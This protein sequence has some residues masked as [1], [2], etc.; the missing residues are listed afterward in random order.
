MQKVEK[1]WSRV[2][3]LLTPLAIGGVFVF[4]AGR[5]AASHQQR[6]KYRTQFPNQ[7][8]GHDLA[9]LVRRAILRKSSRHLHGDDE[10][11]EKAN[12]DDDGQAAHANDVHLDNDVIRVVGAAKEVADRA[13]AEN[14]K[15][16]DSGHRRLQEI[17]QTGPRI[18]RCYHAWDLIIRRKTTPSRS[19]LGSK[20]S[21][22][23]LTVALP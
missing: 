2:K 8:D 20:R 16:L 7:S 4:L 18:S 22:R 13:P 5:I 11:A 3:L 23:S 12:Q 1:A 14:V 6:R 15:I 9:H 19:W 10:T 17:E 21:T